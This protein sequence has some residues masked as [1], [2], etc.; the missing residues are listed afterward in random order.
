M[1]DR[2]PRPEEIGAAVWPHGWYPYEGYKTVHFTF[3]NNL[4]DEG[5]VLKDHL[6][7]DEIRD[8]RYL[9]EVNIK[10]QIDCIDG[11]AIAVD[12]WLDVDEGQRVKGYSYSYHAWLTATEQPVIRYDSAHGLDDLHCHLFDLATREESRFPISTK[13]S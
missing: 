4:L 5:L 7:F 11:L 6:I 2:I 10:G 8:G 1:V 3:M 12:K 9:I 13:S